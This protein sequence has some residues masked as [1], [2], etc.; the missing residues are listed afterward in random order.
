MKI[1]IT[2]DTRDMNRALT[3]LLE[4]NGYDVDSA[5]D[6]EEAEELIMHNGYDAIV[7][8]IM[9]PKKDGIEVL[10]DIRAKN[11]ITPVLMLTAKVEIDD[12]VAGL[13]A[14]ADDYLTKPFAMKEFLARI[15]ALVRRKSEYSATDLSFE[16][17]KLDANEFSLT[18]ENSVR[19]SVKEFELLQT[20]MLNAEKALNT[21]Y[22][23]TH[24]W[25][26]TP[27]ANEEV[28]KLYTMYLKGK[29]RAVASSLT[30]KGDNETGYRLEQA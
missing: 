25:K 5:Y 28:V 24:V 13:D 22:L 14:G 18:C 7:L 26:D 10:K 12:R 15:R 17:I 19:L 4:H 1:L 6:G 30:I 3:V 9:M 8:D 29:L 2:E 16:D 21:N 23:L 27:D 20:L 11:I